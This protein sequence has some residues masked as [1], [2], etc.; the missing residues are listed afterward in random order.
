MKEPNDINQESYPSSAEE[1]WGKGKKERGWEGNCEIEREEKM[2][3]TEKYNWLYS[4]E[5]FTAEFFYYT[6]F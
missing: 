2:R 4:T 3:N 5:T 1:I 6:P